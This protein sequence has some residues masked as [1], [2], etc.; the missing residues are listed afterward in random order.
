MKHQLRKI[1]EYGILL[2]PVV[3]VFRFL[4]LAIALLAIFVISKGDLSTR[5]S[6]SSKTIIPAIISFGNEKETALVGIIQSA[7]LTH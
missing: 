3:N 6:D 7:S 2:F 1:R 4:G 5:H